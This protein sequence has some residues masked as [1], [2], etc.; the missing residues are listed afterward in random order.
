MLVRSGRTYKKASKLGTHVMEG[1]GRMLVTAVGKNSQAGIIYSL[2]N[3]M[4]GDL[5]E[6]AVQLNSLDSP[7]DKLEPIAEKSS[8]DDLKEFNET[9]V[10]P[11]E[12]PK[13]NENKPKLRTKEMSVL[14]LKLTK[15]AIQIGYI[16]TVLAS[17]TV[18]I[19][20]IKFCVIEFAQKGE[21]WETG[22]HL[23]QFIQFF[24]I[25]VTI[26]VVAVPEGLPL[27][28]TLSLAYSVKKMMK[29]LVDFIYNYSYQSGL[30]D[31]LS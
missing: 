29:I 14:Q 10:A 9:N 3:N 19:L 7:N 23:K 5:P 25:G 31:A 13:A 30:T 1:S 12:I 21:T 4:H 24:I 8:E 28:V 2:L 6:T 27:A 20:I 26:L 22:R 17:A 16:G 18:L 11:I 15:L